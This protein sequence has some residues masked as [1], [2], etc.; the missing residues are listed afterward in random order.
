M[1]RL[2]LI[3]LDGWGI[4]DKREGN[5]IKAASTPNIDR[6]RRSGSYTTLKASGSA[7]GL[8]PGFIGNSETGHLHIGSG[9]LTEQPQ[10]RIDNAIKSGEFFQNPILKMA[11]QNERVHFMGLISD[12]GVHSH[13]RHLNALTTMVTG[14]YFVH[15]FLDGRDTPPE[16]AARYLKELPKVS[17]IIGRFYAMD[18]DKRWARTKKA[19]NH[20]RAGKVTKKSWQKVLEEA[21][22][23]GITDEFMNPFFFEDGSQIK[24]GDTVVFFNFR[25][26]RARQLTQMFIEKANVDFVC[27][28]EYSNKFP[29]PVAFKPHYLKNTLG[30][31]LSVNGLKQL[32]VAETEKYAHVTY[33]FNGEKE[34]P[35]AG[36]SR[37]LAAS[38]KVATYDKTPK[39]SIAKLVKA[40]KQKQANYDFILVNLLNA[41]MLGHT[42]K[43]KPTIKGCEAVDKALG[44]LIKAFDGLVVVTADHGNAEKM[45]SKTGDAITSHSTN[46]VPFFHTW[47]EGKAS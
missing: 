6:L 24:D 21:Y 2:M 33:F 4:S 18:R 22:S 44:Q 46:L 37:T 26:D 31:V 41:D 16:S 3:V 19:F 30:E 5:A 27:M 29:V 12:A 47:E 25:A 32:R 36:E 23:K 10:L 35:F 20:L 14:D 15:C 42:G 13:Y 17:S 45:L 40:V 39:M 11:M 28:T 34:K 43:F 7:V 8:P 9:R 1:K 38:P